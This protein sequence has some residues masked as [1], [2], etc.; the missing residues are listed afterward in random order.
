MRHHLL[1]LAIILLVPI[2]L[3]QA[4]TA[5]ASSRAEDLAK[6]EPWCGKPPT[7][8]A[9]VDEIIRVDKEILAREKETRRT[10]LGYNAG[11]SLVGCRI[12]CTIRYFP[13]DT[14]DECRTSIGIF[15]RAAIKKPY[16]W[17]TGLRQLLLEKCKISF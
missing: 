16:L 9:C 8:P 5:P 10:G 2:Q 14:S 4:Q 7:M 17:R 11:S 3:S 13:H 6:Y 1:S 12:Y 15:E